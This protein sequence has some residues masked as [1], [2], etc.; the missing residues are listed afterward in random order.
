M[1]GAI[2]AKIRVN[3]FGPFR[4]SGVN[5]FEKKNTMLRELSEQSLQ[6]VI[7]EAGDIKDIDV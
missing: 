5:V 3:V 4:A 6:V 1:R 7:I 2:L